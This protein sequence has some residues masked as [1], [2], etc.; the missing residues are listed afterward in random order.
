MTDYRKVRLNN[1]TSPQFKH[2]LLLIFWPVYGLVFWFLEKGVLLLGIEPEYTPI[3]TDF[4]F[5]I[6]FC[7]YFMIPY[8]I[9]FV[10]LIWIHVH[11]ALVD[12]PQFKKLM[13]FIMISYTLTLVVYII[14]P[15]R[16]DLRPSQF[17]RDNFLTDWVKGFYIHD[18][19]TNVC[20]SLHVIGSFAVLFTAWN[21]KGLNNL[22]WRSVN[23]ILTAAISVSTV[24]LKQHSIIDIYAG[25][26]VCAIVFPIA[27]I[28]PDKIALKKSV[29][30]AKEIKVNKKDT[31]TLEKS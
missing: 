24:F 30:T 23:L 4:D 22:L 29:K 14:F 11:T 21:T 7:E 6:P 15:N 20:P 12:I 17:P 9:W 27:Y 19:N 28:L 18:T 8:L 16:Q 13:Y 25:F 10:Y 26:A 2:L 31:I 5:Q 3:V 1:L